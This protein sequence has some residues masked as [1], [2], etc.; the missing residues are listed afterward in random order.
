MDK[1]SVIVP[2]YNA[3]KFLDKCLKSL[4]NQTYKDL[5]IIL[6]IFKK[7]II[8][9]STK[10]IVLFSL[11]LTVN[12]F[13]LFSSFIEKYNRTKRNAHI[14]NIMHIPSITII[15]GSISFIRILSI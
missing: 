8:N 12:F 5:E 9:L 15:F 4:I 6:I 13:S 2:I 14:I 3:S 10:L 11:T 1:I 7:N